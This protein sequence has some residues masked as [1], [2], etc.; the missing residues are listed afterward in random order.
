[1]IYRPGRDNIADPLSRL[2]YLEVGTDFDDYGDKVWLNAI[3][4]S[5]AVDVM[6][7]RKATEADEELKVVRKSIL[8]G[9]WQTQDATCSRRLF[10]PFHCGEGH[11]THYRAGYG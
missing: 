4:E 5:I 10:Q 7:L 6:E 3:T 8:T 11:Q 9:D 1:M 2:S